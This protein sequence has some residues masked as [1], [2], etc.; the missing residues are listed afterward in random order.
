MQKREN[1]W[2]TTAFSLTGTDSH[3][4]YPWKS[5]NVCRSLWERETPDNARVA[6]GRTFPLSIYRNAPAAPRGISHPPPLPERAYKNCGQREEGIAV[7]M[8]VR[9]PVSFIAC[10]SIDAF[11]TRTVSTIQSNKCPPKS[12]VQRRTCASCFHAAR[13]VHRV[14]KQA[15]ARHLQT[16]HTGD[17]WTLERPHA[18]NWPMRL[19]IHTTNI[20]RKCKK[21]QWSYKGR[22]TPEREVGRQVSHVKG[23][24]TLC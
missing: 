2:D 10:K 19:D 3:S 18:H 5:A 20:S 21:V 6:V 1:L 12:P 7:S 15:I 17:D 11:R 8:Q 14:A 16:H 4:R 22:T 13:R 24:C 9:A 23:R